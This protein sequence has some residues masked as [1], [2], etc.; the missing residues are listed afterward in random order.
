MAGYFTGALGRGVSGGMLAKNQ[1]LQKN[2]EFEIDMENRELNKKILLG[3]VNDMEWGR[4]EYEANL[5]AYD[6]MTQNI[7]RSKV[8]FGAN[9]R[10]VWDGFV[11]SADGLKTAAD[12]ELEAYKNKTNYRAPWQEADDR[13]GILSKIDDLGSPNI[14]AAM[15]YINNGTP[16]GN[17]APTPAEEKIAFDK[18][19]YEEQKQRQAVLDALSIERFNQSARDNYFQNYA[20]FVNGGVDPGSWMPY[21]QT[22]GGRQQD[23]VSP[24]PVAPAP[25]GGSYQVA[26]NGGGLPAP[27]FAPPGNPLPSTPPAKWAGALSGVAEQAQA[28]RAEEAQARQL[29]IQ[30][31]QLEIQKKQKA[32]AGTQKSPSQKALEAFLKAHGQ[33]AINKMTSVGYST[34]ASPERSWK[35]YNALKTKGWFDDK[36]NFKPGP[37]EDP[38]RYERN[39]KREVAKINGQTTFQNDAAYNEIRK[40][41][42]AHPDWTDTRVLQEL[43]KKHPGW[44]ADAAKWELTWAKKAKPEPKKRF[45]IF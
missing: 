19:K 7:I 34:D 31:T 12:A 26:Q 13:A 2:Q 41:V 14:I 17:V 30:N 38:L 8:P 15:D 45:G 42:A 25:D 43:A 20:S 16:M 44:N 4:D 40:V 23:I 11:P 9:W 10:E 37:A 1:Q 18:A 35:N 22:F 32:L 3:K 28:K 36:G 24:M 29:N 21:P 5:G 6:P 27:G 39:T 33:E